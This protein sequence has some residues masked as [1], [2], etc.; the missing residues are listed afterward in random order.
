MPYA[1][2]LKQPFERL[3]LTQ[4]FLLITALILVVGMAVIGTWVGRQIEN[5]SINR[6][7][8]IA[9]IYVESIV[10]AQQGDWSTPTLDRATHAALDRLFLNGPLQRKVVRFKFWHPDGTIFYSSD[11]TQVG[12]RFG[13]GDRLAA[14]FR[15]ELQGHVTDLG[16]VSHAQDRGLGARLLEVFVPVRAPG[17]DGVVA[18]AEFYYTMENLERDIRNAQQRSWWVVMLGAAGMWALL[19]GL[20]HRANS[21]IV[22]QQRNL[23]AQLAQRDVMLAENERMQERL[24]EAG[25]RTTALNESFVQRTAAHLHDGPAQDLALALLRFESIAEP[26]VGC[27]MASDKRSKDTA[28]L[29]AA[30][31]ASLEDLRSIASSLRIPPGMGHLSLAATVERAVQD[32]ERKYEQQV[33]VDIDDA[34]AEHASMAVKI[35]AYRMIQETLANGW[36]HARGCAQRVR[37]GFADGNVCI[38]V[39]DQGPGFDV[40]KAE[41]SGRLGL[42]LLSERV[43]LLGGRIAIDSAPGRGTRIQAWL[44]LSAEEIVNV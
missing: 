20:V 3:T 22:E 1:M 8:S 28:T 41:E 6:A 35:T 25:A 23:R 4:Q 44:P 24:R 31:N 38:E 26:C 14:A 2:N 29:R 7:I 42:A 9:A 43:Q 5:S 40:A 30:L 27:S 37:L 34:A 21:T 16:E 36:W 39:S 33:A 10:A 32:F 11:H 17:G 19:H 15:G 18:V 12:Q 13:I